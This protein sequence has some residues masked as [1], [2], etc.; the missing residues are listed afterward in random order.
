MKTFILVW[1]GS[2]SDKDKATKKEFKSKR[3]ANF[4]IEKSRRFDKINGCQLSGMSN[5]YEII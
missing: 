3:D 4:F 2:Y 1:S 5:F